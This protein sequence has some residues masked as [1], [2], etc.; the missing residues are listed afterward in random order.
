MS[1]VTNSDS[2][3]PSLKAAGESLPAKQQPTVLRCFIGSLIASAFAFGMYSLTMSIA[4]SFASK[5]V[6]SAN[7]TVIKIGV[8]V[9][10]LVVGMAALGTGV[11]GIAA[12]GLLLLGLQILL[13]KLLKKP[14]V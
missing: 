13:Q 6:H 4:L 11:F 5:P 2:N 9:R 1:D 3:S 7:I 14:A 10:T 12:L 8:A